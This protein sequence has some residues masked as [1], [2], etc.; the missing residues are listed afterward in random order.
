VSS[1]DA[2]VVEYME[3][4]V[5]AAEEGPPPARGEDLAQVHHH[6]HEAEARSGIDDFDP[7]PVRL[8]ELRRPLVR[9]LW[10]QLARQSAHNRDMVA[11][12]SRLTQ[13]VVEMAARIA[14]LERRLG[15]LSGPSARATLASHE[16]ILGDLGT[17]QSQFGTAQAELTGTVE[18]LDTEV[19]ALGQTVKEL[20]SDLR[21]AVRDLAA[22][23]ERG[24]AETAQQKA[25]LNLLIR[26]TKATAEPGLRP[27]VDEIAAIRE[28]ELYADFEARFRGSRE[29]ILARLED[30]DA[31]A[32]AMAALGPVVDIGPGRGEWLE[33]VSA[34]GGQ[35]YGVDTST[36]FV[37]KAAERG[38][39]VR[40]GDGLEHLTQLAPSS[41]GGV[42][43][44]HVV[45]HLT[46]TALGALLDAALLALRPGGWLVFETPNP[47]NIIVGSSTFYLDPTHIRPL[48][49][50]LL[51]FLVEH[52]GFTAPEIRFL[53]PRRGVAS[54]NTSDNA[55]LGDL[56]ADVEWA[57]FGPQDYAVLARKSG[58]A[59]QP[60][61][62]E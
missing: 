49:P 32:R 54:G 28:S 19:S 29:E 5:T 31:E 26:A 27:V 3:R 50:D 41:L 44:F 23:V 58:G 38:I 18:Q 56:L 7:G 37:A 60:T 57:M 47:S 42:T 11:A 55:H 40:L 36:T 34:R 16:V 48:H 17:V 22:D 46:I 10:P 51:A 13:I 62:A 59:E 6:L 61:T 33:F 43:A 8:R 25:R 14:D 35:I 24:G 21:G 20:D 1:D 53:H 12:V 2:N 4:V 15:E 39:D 30:Y 45:E 9:A 52:H